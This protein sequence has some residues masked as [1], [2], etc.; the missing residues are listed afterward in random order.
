MTQLTKNIIANFTGSAWSALMG[1][2]FIPMYIS[3]M[4]VEA[5]GIVGFFISIQAI[6]SILDLGLSQTLNKEMA[7][8][9]TDPLNVKIMADTARTL[10]LIYW[11][12][13]LGIILLLV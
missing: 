9:S 10:E 5:Y 7:R 2:V 4:G 8:L 13:A 12:I 6:F 1:L 3:F 11:G